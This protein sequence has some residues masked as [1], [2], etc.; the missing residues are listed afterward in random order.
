MLQTDGDTE[1]NIIVQ[2]IMGENSATFLL[3][4]CQETVLLSSP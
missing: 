1:E 2:C 4:M 3:Q